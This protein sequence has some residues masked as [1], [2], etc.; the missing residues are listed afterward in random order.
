MVP[1]K[2]R[3]PG[4][5]RIS[6]DLPADVY[7]RLSQLVD[8]HRAQWGAT[9]QSVCRRLL[10]EGLTRAGYPPTEAPTGGKRRRKGKA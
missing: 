9:E 4:I 6:I 3:R 1:R 8:E 7:E 2:E 10:D 5:I